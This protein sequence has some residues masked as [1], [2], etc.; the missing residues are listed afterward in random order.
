MISSDKTQP[1]SRP[2]SM[3]EVHERDPFNNSCYGHVSRHT[4][5][6]GEISIADL[7]VNDF[8]ERIIRGYEEGYAE[9]ELPADL[10]VARSYIP[11]VRLTCGISA[12]WHPRF[13]NT[14]RKT[15]RDV[16]NA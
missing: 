8:N 16:W 7:D 2:P 13:R 6:T 15:A 1:G 14:F 9:K 3:N 4:L 11:A 10:S 12:M 5:Q